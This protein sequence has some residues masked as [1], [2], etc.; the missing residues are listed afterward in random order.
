[1]VD[2]VSFYGYLDPFDAYTMPYHIEDISGSILTDSVKI[3]QGCIKSYVD[4]SLPFSYNTRFLFH[5]SITQSNV[6]L[7]NSL[8]QPKMPYQSHISNENLFDFQ[9]SFFDV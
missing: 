4:P 3:R 9:L 5:H 8:G 7:A 2:M 1:M 6:R